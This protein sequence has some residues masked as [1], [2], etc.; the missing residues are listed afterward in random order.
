MTGKEALE[1]IANLLFMFTSTGRNSGK[2]Y[3][4]KALCKIED[5]L[6]ELTKYKRAFEIL[7][8]K[9]KFKLIK[10]EELDDEDL[11]KYKLLDRTTNITIGLYKEEIELLEELMKGEKRN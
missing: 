11:N 9:Y 8:D 10:N 5:D 6:I 3:T 1:Y 4:L 7:K 2:S